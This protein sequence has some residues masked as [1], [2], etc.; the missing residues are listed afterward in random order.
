MSV[1]D[2]GR[3]GHRSPQL[4]LG[5]AAARNLATT[6]KSAPQ[7]Q[8]ITSRWLLRVLPWVQARGGAYRVNRRLSYTIGDGRVEFT[9]TGAEVRVIPAELRELPL[10]RGYDDPDVLTALAG[11][12]KQRES[13][14]GRRRSSR[15]ARPP[16]RSLLIAHG[17]V[18]KLGEA[19]YGDEA[20]LDVWPTATTSATQV[21]LEDDDV[22]D[23]TR[24][25]VTTRHRPDAV[26]QKDFERVVGQNE[27]LGGAHLDAFKALPARPQNKPGEAEIALASGHAGRADAAGHVRRLRA[28]AARVRAE[29]RADRAAGPHAR[30]RPLQR[31]DEPDRAAAALTIEALRERQEHEMVN[32][33]EFGLLHNADLKQRIHTRTGPPTPDDLDELLSRRRAIAVPARAPAHDRGVRPASAPS[34]G[35]IR[36][37]VDAARHEVPA[38]RGVPLLPCNKIPISDAR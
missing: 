2:A 38:W 34:A 3:A 4:S 7:M 18:E 14:A 37:N 23:F 31:A 20:V 19:K 13:R 29:R 21:L 5:T 8:G 26:S 10:L 27:A 35:S 16:T 11:K 1:T 17:K 25:A 24:E 12:F 6:T 22:W 15:R 9:N 33:R 36:D 32:N 28:V 30:R